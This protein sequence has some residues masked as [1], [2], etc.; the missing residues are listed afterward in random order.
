MYAVI[1]T[2]ET[3][4]LDKTYFETAKRMRDLAINKYGCIKFTSVVEG[5]KEISIS[6]WN[7]KKQIKEWKQNKEHQNAQELGKNKW[8]YTYSV[9]VVEIIQEYSKNT[10]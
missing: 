8:Y 1:F 7:N 3:K 4:N 9:Q 5:N 6:Y 10:T 2:A